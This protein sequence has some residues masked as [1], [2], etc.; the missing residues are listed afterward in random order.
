MLFFKKWADAVN[1]KNIKI[2]AC[3]SKL[4]LAKVGAFFLRQWVT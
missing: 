1:Q 4:E 2:S 3:L